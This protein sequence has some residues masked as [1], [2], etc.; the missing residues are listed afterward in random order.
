MWEIIFI[1][2]ISLTYPSP[3]PHLTLTFIVWYRIAMWEIGWE[4]REGLSEGLS[5]GWFFKN[6]LFI[7]VSRWSSEGWEIFIKIFLKTQKSG[8]LFE[9]CLWVVRVMSSC[10]S[11]DANEVFDR[12]LRGYSLRWNSS[13]PT[14]E[15]FMPNVGT[16]RSQAG[17]LHNRKRLA[18]QRTFSLIT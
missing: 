15:Q 2:H 14:W 11:T 17:N 5:E 10:C 9:P 12:V 13:S 1:P 6:D 4:I 3:N 8:I 18:S 16:T 7:R